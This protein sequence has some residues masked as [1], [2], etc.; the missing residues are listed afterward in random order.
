VVLLFIS[1]FGSVLLHKYEVLEKTLH[2]GAS[3]SYSNLLIK[4]ADVGGQK[5]VYIGKIDLKT[6]ALENAIILTLKHNAFYN[7]LNCKSGF[8]DKG[9][10]RLSDCTE[11]RQDESFSHENYVLYTNL[12]AQDILNYSQEM[13][14]VPF[15]SMPQIIA[16]SEKLGMQTILLEL[17]YYKQLFRPIVIVLLGLLP[18]YFFRANKSKILSNTID[19]LIIGI[20]SFL[21]VHIATNFL[22]QYI[23]SAIICNSLPILCLMLIIAARLKNSYKYPI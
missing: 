23:K 15:W 5:F 3:S 11:Y 2:S 4:D 19:S 12:K 7:R 18:F 1:S 20:I 14:N 6:H 9:F 17:Y 21:C 10:W 22:V 16:S 13:Y 8:I